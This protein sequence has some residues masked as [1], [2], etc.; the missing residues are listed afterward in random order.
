VVD[1]LRD[2]GP[3]ILYGPPGTGKTY[4]ARKLAAFLAGNEGHHEV[5]QFHPMLDDNRDVR[6]MTTRSTVQ[7][8]G[9]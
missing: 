2:R 4:I 7:G 8:G 1:L 5:V 3:V 9:D 6:C